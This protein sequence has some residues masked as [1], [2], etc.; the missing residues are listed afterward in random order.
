VARIKLG[1]IAKA[2]KYILWDTKGRRIISVDQY[3]QMKAVA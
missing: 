1:D 2:F 3:D